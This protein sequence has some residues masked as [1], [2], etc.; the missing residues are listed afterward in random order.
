MWA[1]LGH[2]VRASDPL[3]VKYDGQC[4]WAQATGGWVGSRC[5]RTVPSILPGDSVEPLK[6][7]PVGVPVSPVFPM[8]AETKQG[9]SPLRE[10]TQLAGGRPTRV[11]LCCWVP[12][13]VPL[14]KG[15]RTSRVTIR[16]CTLCTPP[17]T[18][19]PDPSHRVFR[20]R[21]PTEPL[22]SVCPGWHR[23]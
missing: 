21:H 8:G 7:P 12:S 18:H 10:S 13:T 17:Q 3:K 11:H 16:P 4:P 19:G 15:L 22:P 23:G 5:L 9:L 1:F 2:P 14:H 20:S 6:C